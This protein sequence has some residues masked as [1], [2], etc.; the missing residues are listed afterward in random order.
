MRFFAC[1]LETA[2]SIT[3]WANKGE[4][5]VSSEALA[6]LGVSLGGPGGQKAL[7]SLRFKGDLV[8][9]GKKGNDKH[10]Q[11]VNLLLIFGPILGALWVTVAS[12]FVQK[13]QGDE[14]RRFRRGKT[15]GE[16]KGPE[17]TTTTSRKRF[18]LVQNRELHQNLGGP[19]FRPLVFRSQQKKFGKNGRATR[20][21]IRPCGLR[22][23]SGE[24]KGEA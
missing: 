10:N 15:C 11:I 5:G 14:E 17:I 6:A 3:I 21:W 20:F 19:L 12:S 4:K 22:G 24:G 18:R 7:L 16:T 13:Q 8:N 9:F 1:F 23:V 2:N